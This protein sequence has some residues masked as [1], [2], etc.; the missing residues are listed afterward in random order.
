MTETTT[1]DP[2]GLCGSALEKQARILELGGRGGPAEC[3]VRRIVSR[4]VRVQGDTAADAEEMD[5]TEAALRLV[6]DGRVGIW[7]GSIPAGEGAI[8]DAVGR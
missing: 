4:S 1:S 2:Y 6:R 5:R 7:G 8:T 3:Y